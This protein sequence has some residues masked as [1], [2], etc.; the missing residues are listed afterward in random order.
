MFSVTGTV[1]TLSVASSPVSSRTVTV[2]YLTSS[3]RRNQC[4]SM[5]ATPATTRRTTGRAGSPTPSMPSLVSGG[6]DIVCYVSVYVCM[7]GVDMV[8]ELYFI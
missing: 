1:T 2:N 7:L 4:R 8:V 3:S 6:V 5:T